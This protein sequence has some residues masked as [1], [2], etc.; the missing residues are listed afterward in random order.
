MLV[1]ALKIDS[2]AILEPKKMNTVRLSALQPR[3]YFDPKNDAGTFQWKRVPF[4]L[5]NAPATFQR[6]LDILLSGYRWQTCLVY[7][8]EVILFS[9]R[10]KEHVQKVCEILSVLKNDSLS[11]KL[12]KCH[13]FKESVDYLGHIIGPGKLQVALKNTEATSQSQHPATQTQLPPFW[14][15]AISTGGSYRTSPALPPRST[16]YSKRGPPLTEE[17][18]R[19]FALLKEA[20]T[21]PPILRGSTFRRRR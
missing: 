21:E 17:Q 5:T 20:L 9:R 18:A 2:Q 12:R 16:S 7:L 4:G 3:L 11:L 15:C 1:N 13:F 10:F 19:A 6:Q 14:D 8:D